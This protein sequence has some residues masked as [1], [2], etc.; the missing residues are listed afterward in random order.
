VREVE[1]TPNPA[2]TKDRIIAALS[3]IGTPA[4]LIC[5]D[6]SLLDAHVIQNT[7]FTVLDGK[8]L[9]N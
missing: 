1:C 8:L 5:H 4:R 3:G 2:T 6:R 7:G 9:D